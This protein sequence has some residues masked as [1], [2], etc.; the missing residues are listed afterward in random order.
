MVNLY[1]TR[2]RNKNRRIIIY[3]NKV[4]PIESLLSNELFKSK[5]L[6]FESKIFIYQSYKIIYGISN[7]FE[8]QFMEK[9]TNLMKEENYEEK[10]EEIGSWNT[11]IFEVKKYEIRIFGKEFVKNNYSKCLIIYNN[12]IFHLKEYFSFKDI[13][14]EKDK[15]EI[16][17]L[18][19]EN[20]DNFSYMFE[21][22]YSLEKFIEIN[23]LEK[24]IA[25]KQI[26]DN[27]KI[28]TEIYDE[29]NEID[30]DFYNDIDI[31]DTSNIQSFSYSTFIGNLSTIKNKISELN[32]FNNSKN[33]FFQNC[34]DRCLINLKYPKKIKINPL[35]F[36]FKFSN[37]IIIVNTIN[38][39]FCFCP[40]LIS[41]PDISKWNTNNVSN[42]ESLFCFCHSLISLPDISKWNTINITNTVNMFAGCDSLKS[43][44]DISKWNTNKFK[45]MSFMFYRCSSLI[46][47]PDISKWNINNVKYMIDI[48]K[49]CNSLVS[50][51]DFSKW[52]INRAKEC[53]E[54]IDM[55]QETNEFQYKDK[56]KKFKFNNIDSMNMYDECLSLLSLP[57]FKKSSE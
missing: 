51:Q 38:N 44:P 27:N 34:K 41:L 39:M 11:Q 54:F 22:C 20:I 10:L 4:R 15:L 14:K 12:R 21:N 55:E 8:M 9:V 36:N 37:D 45:D 33:F 26:K 30:G 35:I 43:L 19:I 6:F 23:N 56:F 42:M 5:Y 53:Y 24:S 7:I 31:Y 57:N 29:N 46:S 3:N 18:A 32:S 28:C 25:M 17:L 52:N 50:L 2:I 47:L 40:S 13:Q 48:F 49:G 16:Q 1:S